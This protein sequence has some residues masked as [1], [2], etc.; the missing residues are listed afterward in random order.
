LVNRRQLVALVALT[1]VFGLVRAASGDE[2]V[3]SWAEAK[4]VLPITSRPVRPIVIDM[5]P[6]ATNTF[7]VDAA[8]VVF[9]SD[10]VLRFLLQVSS[11]QGATTVSF[12]G[13][14]CE[15]REQRRY[16]YGRADGSWTAARNE[17]WLSIEPR[18]HNAYAYVLYREFFCPNGIAVRD[19][20]EA[21]AILERGGAAT[22][23]DGW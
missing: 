11:P 4:V 6:T 19:S 8:S 5:G 22:K 3:A 14:R 23:R 2:E 1:V 18:A 13:I 21:I 7:S 10:R 17:R 20:A 15:T 12:E 16:A 9:G